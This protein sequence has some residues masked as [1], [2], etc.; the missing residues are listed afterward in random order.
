VTPEGPTVLV[1]SGGN[2]DPAFAA[3]VLAGDAPLAER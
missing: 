1:L 2:V 3:A